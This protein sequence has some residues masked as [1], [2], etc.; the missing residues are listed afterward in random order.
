MKASCGLIDN[1][2]VECKQ[3]WGGVSEAEKM[4]LI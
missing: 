3:D 1:L 4:L 2:S